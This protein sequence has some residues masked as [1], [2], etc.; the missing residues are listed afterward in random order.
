MRDCLR[1]SQ[2]P[3]WLDNR[4]PVKATKQTEYLT[5]PDGSCLDPPSIYL[6]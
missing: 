1:T 4:Q 3:I 6:S 2:E 5:L